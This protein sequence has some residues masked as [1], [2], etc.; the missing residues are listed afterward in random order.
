M[1]YLVGLCLQNN[2]HV[3]APG[4]TGTGKT[5][6]TQEMLTYGLPEEFQALVMT[7]SA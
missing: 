4:P 1:K 3:L 2:K 5:V 7:F 6:N